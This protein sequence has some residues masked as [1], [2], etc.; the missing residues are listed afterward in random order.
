MSE[1]S[2]PDCG[3]CA[4]LRPRTAGVQPGWRDEAAQPAVWTPREPSEGWDSFVIPAWEMTFHPG[5]FITVVYGGSIT[6]RMSSEP[7]K[8]AERMVPTR[9]M[10]PDPEPSGFIKLDYNLK[11]KPADD[12]AQHPYYRYLHDGAAMRM[13]ELVPDAEDRYGELSWREVE[14]RFAVIG[15]DG[16]LREPTTWAEMERRFWVGMERTFDMPADDKPKRHGGP[17]P[18]KTTKAAWR[19]SLR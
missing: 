7:M 19:K 14:D 2:D 13:G 12:E 6:G 9:R 17:P 15:R 16:S 10:V 11:D 3:V 8:L 4:V 1:C 18:Q 5:E